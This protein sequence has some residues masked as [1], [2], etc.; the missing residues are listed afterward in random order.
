MECEM[1]GNGEIGLNYEEIKGNLFEY[2]TTEKRRQ[3]TF[4]K[5]KTKQKLWRG[6]CFFYDED[7][8]I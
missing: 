8:K 1:E 3:N 2:I 6:I 4:D 5:N 7:N